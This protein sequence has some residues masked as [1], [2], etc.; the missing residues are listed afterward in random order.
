MINR[1]NL[2]CAS[3]SSFM[4]RMR[5]A[6]AALS[7]CAIASVLRDKR[8][9]F[10]CL[11]ADK[12]AVL[13]PNG[14]VRA[15]EL[16]DWHIGNVRDYGCDFR[17]LWKSGLRKGIIRNIREG[18]CFCTHECFITASLIFR[19]K[20]ILRILLKTLSSDAAERSGPHIGTCKKTIS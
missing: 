12:I 18:K 4:Q 9:R 17:K 11:A 3:N 7:R 16:K 15:C 6:K 14:D 19:P 2:K 8:G 5:F 10:D 13:Y 1:Y 20:G